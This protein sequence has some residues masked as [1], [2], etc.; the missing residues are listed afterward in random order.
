MNIT[1]IHEKDEVK[2]EWKVQWSWFG[3]VCGSRLRGII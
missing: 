1:A 3:G 2:E